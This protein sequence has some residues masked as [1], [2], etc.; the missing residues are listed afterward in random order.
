MLRREPGL[1]VADGSGE[2]GHD[3]SN[4]PTGDVER[5]RSRRCRHDV[6]KGV[7]TA[8]TITDAATCTVAAAATAVKVGSASATACGTAAELP[9]VLHA[10]APAAPEPPNSRSAVMHT[11]TVTPTTVKP[12]TTPGSPA[13][14]TA[15]RS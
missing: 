8:V 3:T 12:S 6:R 14:T 13:V 11:A 2:E 9:A 15:R 4:S 10:A 5:C 7:S 1:E